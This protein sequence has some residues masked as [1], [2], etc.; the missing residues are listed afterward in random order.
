MNKLLL[1]LVA[2]L[3]AVAACDKVAVQQ[4][5][6][7]ENGVVV[8]Q[9]TGPTKTRAEVIKEYNDFRA[10]CKVT[11]SGYGCNGFEGPVPE[12]STGPGK[13]RAEVS[14]ELKDFLAECKAKPDTAGCT[15]QP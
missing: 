9:Y 14:K 11:P 15:A 7:N 3:L 1:I 10:A 6:I 8:P 5:V 2:S 4:P 13:T 12:I